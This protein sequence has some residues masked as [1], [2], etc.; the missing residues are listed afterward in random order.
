[1]Y[2]NRAETLAERYHSAAEILTFYAQLV[3]GNLPSDEP[4]DESITRHLHDL[5]RATREPKLTEARPDCCPCCGAKP[6]VAVLRPEAD[7]SRRALICARCAYE[8]PYQ[9][10]L[11]PNCQEQRFDSLPIYIA[12]DFP[13][14]RVECCSTC[15]RYLISSDLLKD[16]EAI[17]L[18]EDIAAL[19]LHLW[20]TDR[21]YTKIEANLLGF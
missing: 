10:I 16:S 19:S 18:V 4:L 3:T 17:P 5:S 14:L 2:A 20:A 8:W 11:C 12:E 7:G 9:R 15:K 13:H 21:G 1:M 6:G